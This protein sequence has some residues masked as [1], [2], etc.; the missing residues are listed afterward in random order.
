MVNL[1]Y[2]FGSTLLALVVASVLHKDAAAGRNWSEV[3]GGCSQRQR[4]SANSGQS[5]CG[6]SLDDVRFEPSE[7]SAE[8]IQQ[9][10]GMKRSCAYPKESGACGGG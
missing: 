5:Y 8:Y 1:H 10:C 4:A 3:R 6:C 7:G 9:A 2:L